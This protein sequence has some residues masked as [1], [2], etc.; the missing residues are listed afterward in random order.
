[1]NASTIQNHFIEPSH[2]NQE[3]HTDYVETQF[4]NALTKGGQEGEEFSGINTS[5][6][7]D[8]LTGYSEADGFMKIGDIR[9]EF[10]PS[11]TVNGV[12]DQVAQLTTGIQTGDGFDTVT[13]RDHNH[14]NRSNWDVICDVGTS[15]RQV[16]VADALTNGGTETY[17]EVEWT[18]LKGDVWTNGSATSVRDGI[19]G[20]G[21]HGG[22]A[23]GAVHPDTPMDT[24]PN[25]NLLGFPGCGADDLTNYRPEG[26]SEVEIHFAT[27]LVDQPSKSELD[28]SSTKYNPGKGASFGAEQG[29]GWI[30]IESMV[31]QDNM[32]GLDAGGMNY[33][34]AVGLDSSTVDVVNNLDSI[35]GGCGR[36]GTPH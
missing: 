11:R 18:Y 17:T 16:S 20:S 7:N 26:F 13:F 9:G 32:Q 3:R 31:N 19:T 25:D 5:S 34:E 33:A 10:S 23:N 28:K 14:S 29:E 35:C 27:P 2:N 30:I 15:I 12:S 8:C 36:H 1:M 24:H 4:E 21:F 6:N 22:L